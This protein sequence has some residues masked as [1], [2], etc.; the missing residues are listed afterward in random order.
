MEAVENL[1]VA[2][3]EHVCELQRLCGSNPPYSPHEDE[4]MQNRAMYAYIGDKY[5]AYNEIAWKYFTPASKNALVIDEPFN[6]RVERGE[7]EFDMREDRFHNETNYWQVQALNKMINNRETARPLVVYRGVTEY[8]L[9]KK[10]GVEKVGFRG[11]ERQKYRNVQIDYFDTV[12]QPGSVIPL[13]GFLS[14]TLSPSYAAAIA[15][16]GTNHPGES[17]RGGEVTSR[18]FLLQFELPP[19]FPLVYTNSRGEYECILPYAKTF[20]YN[21]GHAYPHWLVAKRD[22]IRIRYRNPHDEMLGAG[23]WTGKSQTATY[24]TI[25]RV[26]LRLMPWS[27]ERVALNPVRF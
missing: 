4:Q 25:R 2:S 1:P 11:Y 9:R 17:F 19:G 7:R 18:G 16:D 10:D 14:T 12:L 8:S 22:T 26:V 20:R 6:A 15:T 13:Y 23:A 27:T 21:S 3:P 5:R 24:V